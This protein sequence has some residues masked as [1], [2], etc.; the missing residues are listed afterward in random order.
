MKVVLDTNVVVSAILRG[1]RPAEII[2]FVTEQPDIE[3]VVSSE[4]LEEYRNVIRRPKFG[5]SEEIVRQWLD[6][7]DE[8]ASVVEVTLQV[9]FPR[10]QKDAKFLACA[11]ATHADY[12]V[13]GDHDFEEAQRY[14]RTVII[15]VS[16]FELLVMRKWN[17]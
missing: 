3:W 10:D 6:L 15:S 9:D 13:T 17:E 11:F 12:L 7:I 5:L 4:I 16:Q 1:R 2:L 8:M 14:G